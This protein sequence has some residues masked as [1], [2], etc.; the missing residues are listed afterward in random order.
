M[1]KYVLYI[2]PHLHVHIY[3]SCVCVC[4]CVCAYACVCVVSG[5]QTTFWLTCAEWG[6]RLSSFF[7]CP[8]DSSLC[9]R[10]GFTAPAFQRKR[11]VDAKAAKFN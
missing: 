5:P 10:P 6:K 2:H 7:N 9:N 1:Y 4:V 8:L 3:I 11:L